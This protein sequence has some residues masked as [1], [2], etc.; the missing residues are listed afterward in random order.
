MRNL[1][2][3]LD[4]SIEEIDEMIE[5]ANDIIDNPDKYREACKYK[6]TLNLRNTELNK[7]F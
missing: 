7:D 4:L 5:V 1:I 3:I 2:D 6:M